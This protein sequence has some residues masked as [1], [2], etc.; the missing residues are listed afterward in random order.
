MTTSVTSPSAVSILA[1]IVLYKVAPADSPTLK[2]LLA[3]LRSVSPGSLRL[4]VILYD[5]T[6]GG[7]VCGQL[8]DGVEYIASGDNT[9][10]TTAYN[11]AA[12]TGMDR[13]FDWL[14]TLDQDT[15]LPEN[16]LAKLVEIIRRNL[17][18]PNLAAIVP[19][20]VGSGRTLSPNWFRW[21]RLLKFFPIGYEGIPE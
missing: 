18:N 6:P 14:L 21:G 20:I 7:Q 15:S 13:G 19:L 16:F 11:Y 5:N 4:E 12:K 8:F 17:R 1:V 10:L 9:G 2:T 3:A